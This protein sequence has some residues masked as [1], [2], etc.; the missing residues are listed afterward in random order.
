M[1]DMVGCQPVCRA[2][3]PDC[4]VCR[5]A[6]LG[7]EPVRPAP[8][9]R[10]LERRARMHARQPGRKMWIATELVEHL[11]HLA[12]KPHLDVGARECGPDEEFAALERAIDVT[13]MIG[14]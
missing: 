1:Q 11:C 4:Q 6:G 9:D 14:K 7:R 2:L 5:L 8:L 10:A 13:Q 12:N 3:L